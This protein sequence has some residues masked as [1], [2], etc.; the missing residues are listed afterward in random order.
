M[1]NLLPEPLSKAPERPAASRRVLRVCTHCQ[2][3]HCW[4]YDACLACLI[5]FQG[6]QPPTYALALRAEPLHPFRMLNAGRYL[7]ALPDSSV[8]TGFFKDLK[9]SL[10]KVCEYLADTVVT[11]Y[12]T[13]FFPASKI[14][15]KRRATRVERT[16]FSCTPDGQQIAHRLA[17]MQNGCC[18]YCRKAAPLTFDVMLPLP[19]LHSSNIGHQQTLLFRHLCLDSGLVKG[20]CDDCHYMK[21]RTEAGAYCVWMHAREGL[22][23]FTPL[24]SRCPGYVG[25]PPLEYPLPYFHGMGVGQA[26]AQIPMAPDG[27]WAHTARRLA[28]LTMRLHKPC[29]H[30]NVPYRVSYDASIRHL[31]F[32]CATCPAP[33]ETVGVLTLNPNRRLGRAASAATT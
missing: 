28:V 27:V 21:S 31:G 5:G 24:P 14:G 26:T 10:H 3:P 17:D 25:D 4:S 12:A 1:T 9:L 29:N 6:I 8:T 15:N 19:F 13:A 2:T 16:A 11:P 18:A 7:M 23:D 33:G 22:Y 20:A 30:M 32:H